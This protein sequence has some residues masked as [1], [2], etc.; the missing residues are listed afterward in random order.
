MEAKYRYCSWMCNLIKFIA[1]I[2]A[3]L[4][5]VSCP[6]PSTRT[7]QCCDTDN[8]SDACRDAKSQ[9]HRSAGNFADPSSHRTTRSGQAEFS[10]LGNLTRS[11]ASSA[12]PIAHSLNRQHRRHPTNP[13]PDIPAHLHISRS[14][15]GA[16]HMRGV[17]RYLPRRTA[18][19]FSG[20]PSCRWRCQ[21]LEVI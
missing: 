11:Q 18:R 17:P 21:W 19:C 12:P 8:A 13:N 2:F 3:S 10:A 16:F 6:H 15:T 14:T 9:A 1:C 5:A 4:T 7:Y 20:A